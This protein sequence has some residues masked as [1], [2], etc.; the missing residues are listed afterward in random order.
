MCISQ[1]TYLCSDRAKIQFG[2]ICWGDSASFSDLFTTQKKCI[3]A[4]LGYRYKCS[5]LPLMSCKELFSQLK[6]LTLPSLFILECAK[7]CRKH[8]HYFR[9]NTATHS[10]N[11]RRNTDISVTDTNKSPSNNVAKVYNKLPRNIKEIKSD[12]T[13]VKTFLVVK[14]YYKVKDYH[15]EIWQSWKWH[16]YCN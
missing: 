15:D 4:L 8:P 7:F 10:H 3:R 16:V 2:I 13:F 5:N 14:C 1:C 6:I 11:T 12:N 9:L